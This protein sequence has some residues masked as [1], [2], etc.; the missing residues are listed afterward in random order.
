MS[1]VIA[2]IT[3][4]LDGSDRPAPT[5]SMGSATRRAPHVGDGTGRV[6]TEISNGPRR[7]VVRGHGPAAVRRHRRPAG[8][9]ETWDTAR[10]NRT[11]PFSS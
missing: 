11:P 8:W 9:N 2:D 5:N 10:F 6:D 4:S 7:R 1:K 3:M